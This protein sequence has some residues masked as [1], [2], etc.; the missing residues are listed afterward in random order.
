KLADR[1][2]RPENHASTSDSSPA[3]LEPPPDTRGR[4]FEDLSPN[5]H[6]RDR[7]SVSDSIA[8]SAV[9]SSPHATSV[10]PARRADARPS[11]GSRRYARS[12][13]VPRAAEHGCARAPP[14]PKPPRAAGDE[15]AHDRRKG[16]WAA[17]TRHQ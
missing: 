6:P 4:A 5:L 16:G 10:R 9:L 14:A 12:H 17:R 7:A 1:P 2:L 8:Y 15:G 11:G 3:I 13:L